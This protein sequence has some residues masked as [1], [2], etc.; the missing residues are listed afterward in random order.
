MRQ[1]YP[2]L[3]RHDRFQIKFFGRIIH[4]RV[5]QLQIRSHPFKRPRPV[6]NDRTQPRRVR[7]RPHNR[8]VA[9]APLFF[10]KCP[11]LRP[12]CAARHFTTPTF[13]KIHVLKKR[14]YVLKKRIVPLRTYGRSPRCRWRCAAPPPDASRMVPPAS[15]PGK[16]ATP[17]P[18][19]R[20]VPTAPTSHPASEI[21]GTASLAEYL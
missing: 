6:K 21:S 15:P 12:R 20:L 9:F 3:H 1:L 18:A 2:V 19:L 16:P 7:P 4:A 5:V 8:D 14:A 17:P 11:G 10:K 13:L